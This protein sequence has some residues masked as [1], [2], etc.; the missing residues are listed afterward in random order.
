MQPR[1]F[2]VLLIAIFTVSSFS[3][4]QPNR[5]SSRRAEDI[6]AAD[7]GYVFKDK[8]VALQIRAMFKDVKPSADNDS[9]DI[10][11]SRYNTTDTIGKFYRHHNGNYIVCT[12][13]IILVDQIEVHFVMEVEP[14]GNILRNEFFYDGMHLC[15]WDNM[16]DGFIRK[17]NYYFLKECGTGSGYC[18]TELYIFK[19]LVSKDSL[20]PL[21]INYFMAPGI[22]DRAYQL[23]SDY[24]LHHNTLT[25]HYVLEKLK[26]TKRGYKVRN[27]KKFTIEYL[28]KQGNWTA[29][30]ST[31]L[32]NFYY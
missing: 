3:R 11:G 6:F 1:H 16:R 22:D 32:K 8:A 4:I 5:L 18:S 10:N 19:E 21:N 31:K 17:D 13:N 12:K 2:I 9:V 29:T 26:D 27:R 25:V 20:K 30:D 24:T 15:C 14:D 7:S 28:E 23:Q